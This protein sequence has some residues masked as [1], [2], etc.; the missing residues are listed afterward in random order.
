MNQ[1]TEVL[2]GM[3]QI[4]KFDADR[5]VSITIAGVNVA[6][7]AV[8]DELLAKVMEL[9]QGATPVQGKGVRIIHGPDVEARVTIRET[10]SADSSGVV[11]TK[12][13]VT[14]VDVSSLKLW[15]RPNMAKALALFQ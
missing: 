10:A 8:E 6:K 14:G 5:D 11:T 3:V 9:C 1:N 4:K 12:R 2:K 13:L 7:G 15:T